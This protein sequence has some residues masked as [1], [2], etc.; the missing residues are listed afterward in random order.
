[1]GTVVKVSDIEPGSL[2]TGYGSVR[3]VKPSLIDDGETSEVWIAED[4]NGLER[5]LL[6]SSLRVE[7]SP[8]DYRSVYSH[9][10]SPGSIIEDPRKSGYW[11]SVNSVDRI[12]ETKTGDLLGVKL[13][14]TGDHSGVIY[15]NLHPWRVLKER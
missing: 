3:G 7:V 6:P 2:L 15:L 9:Q 5:L 1:M 14:V 8:P 10:V 11:L 13:G 4:P 12:D